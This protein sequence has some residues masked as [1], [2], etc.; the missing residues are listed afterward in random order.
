MKYLI[1]IAVLLSAC[2]TERK[3]VK[4]LNENPKV[5]SLYCADKFPVKETFI[6]GKEIIKSDTVTTIDTVITEHLV[7][8]ETVYIKSISK[9][10]KSITKYISVTDTIVKENTTRVSYLSDRAK[11]YEVLYNAEQKKAKKLIW[12]IVGFALSVLG[13]ILI[14]IKK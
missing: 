6:K 8:G 4:Y 2:T 7:K 14:I 9:P 5:S 13:L 10:C 1:F 11:E 3:V 12:W